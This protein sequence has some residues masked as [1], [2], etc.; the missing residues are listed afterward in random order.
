MLFIANESK[1]G[2]FMLSKRVEALLNWYQKEK[3]T[4]PWR[5]IK[6]T[7][8]VWV[9]EIMLQQTRVEAVKG[10]FDRFVTALV[11]IEA[12]AGAKEEQLLKL[13]EG[14]G[15]YNRVRN[16]QKAAKIVMNDYD[17]ELPA[18]FE[19]LKKLP[20][21]GEYTAGAIASIA[22]QIPVPAVDGNVLRVAKR[23]ACSFDDITNPSVKK[24]LGQDLARIIP[25]N[26]PG[27]FNQALMELG[28]LVC[29]PNGRPDCGICPI[30]YLCRAYQEDK[31]LM[32]PEKPDKK[33]RRIE[34]K[35][36]LLMEYQDKYL[37]RKRPPKGLL[38]GL[39]ELPGLE[40]KLKPEELQIELRELGYEDFTITPLGEARHIFTHIE[41]HMT[42][43]HVH[44]S[45]ENQGSIEVA[46]YLWAAKEEILRNYCIPNAFSSY[47]KYL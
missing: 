27:D 16:L 25:G 2:V 17:G 26:R 40:E 7:Y 1:I 43:Y 3:R 10:Y 20:G 41:W 23:I 33:E 8:A 18:D 34:N 12:L 37:I 35:T 39:W 24:E 38:A 29:I 4:L 21:I 13:W 45:K 47:M 31:V 5:G 36:I 19:M 22:Y 9:S 6:D 28:A 11:D 14:L 30:M 32:L 44:F 42:G 15:Y 46:S